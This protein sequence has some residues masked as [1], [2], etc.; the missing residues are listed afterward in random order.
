MYLEK[1]RTARNRFIAINLI[2]IL[3]GAAIMYFINKSSPLFLAGP[4]LLSAGGVRM[5]DYKIFKLGEQKEIVDELVEEWGLLDIQGGRGRAEK[6]QYESLMLRCNDKL[7]IQA[8]SLSRFQTDLGDVLE[9][10]GDQNVEIR[11]LLLDPDSQIC[12]WY[13]ETDPERGDLSS[14]IQDST[15]QFIER[16]IDSLE[17]RYYNGI[18]MNYF[19]IDSKAFV[20]P[21]FMSEPSRST[22]TFLGRTDGALVKSYTNNFEALWEDSRVPDIAE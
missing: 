7:H 11:L 16:N 19:R 18:P 6:D 5:L 10:L 4:S 17:V 9:R 20:G 2:S 3:I 22:L 8:I 14:T 12:E 21:Y 1:Y 15:K 13:G